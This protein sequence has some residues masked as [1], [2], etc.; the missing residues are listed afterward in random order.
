MRENISEESGGR[1]RRMFIFFRNPNCGNESFRLSTLHCVFTLWR[2]DKPLGSTSPLHLHHRAGVAAATVTCPCTCQ[3]L[4]SPHYMHNL[5]RG[6]EIK[7]YY[8]LHVR[9]EDS[10]AQREKLACTKS[11]SQE[12]ESRN[13]SLSESRAWPPSHSLLNLNKLCLAKDFW[14]LYLNTHRYS[15][16]ISFINTN[17]RVQ[18]SRETNPP[19]VYSSPLWAQ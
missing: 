5:A 11:C 13:S 6:S 12:V 19:D 2:A 9:D 18:C 1:L 3:T 7:Y 17:Q 15:G 4:C 14:I 8:Y 10:K 16:N